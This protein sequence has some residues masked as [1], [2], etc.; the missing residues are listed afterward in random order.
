MVLSNL[1]LHLDPGIFSV[2]RFWLGALIGRLFNFLAA[3]DRH[4]WSD[5]FP[6]DVEANLELWALVELTL[7]KTGA[8]ESL[9]RVSDVSLALLKRALAENDEEYKISTLVSAIKIL[10]RLISCSFGLAGLDNL[11]LTA[12]QRLAEASCFEY[13][14]AVWL[15]ELLNSLAELTG[16]LLGRLCRLDLYQLLASLRAVLTSALT[17]D[18]DNAHVVQAALSVVGKVTALD[19]IS[20][21]NVSTSHYRCGTYLL[22]ISF[23]IPEVGRVTSVYGGYLGIIS[24]HWL[25]YSSAFQDDS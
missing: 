24:Y 17:G 13:I 14:P 5:H 10:D 25:N 2:Q 8:T 23:C 7:M 20:S 3:A 1:Y 16:S 11:I 9:Q 15:A 21:V 18:Q 22:F 4:S 12:W 19:W 6:P